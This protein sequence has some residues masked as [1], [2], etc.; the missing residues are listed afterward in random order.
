[1]VVSMNRS[2]GDT[3]LTIRH[4]MAKINTFAMVKAIF[5]GEA[6]YC[7][8]FIASQNTAGSPSDAV[9]INPMSTGCRRPLTADPTPEESA[10]DISISKVCTVAGRT[11]NK[12]QQVIEYGDRLRNDPSDNP[13]RQINCNP[14]SDRNEALLMHAG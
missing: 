2:N 5:L 13:A 6:K 12:T 10:L 8:L 7:P 9:S 3:G 14:R 11:Y 4:A 1:M